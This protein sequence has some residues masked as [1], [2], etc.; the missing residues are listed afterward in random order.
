VGSL[1]PSTTATKPPSAREGVRS[2]YKSART[3]F[4]KHVLNKREE[5]ETDAQAFGT[6]AHLAILEPTEFEK[7]Y[8]VMPEF[9]DFRSSKNREARGRVARDSPG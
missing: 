9:G 6:A 4:R 5:D 8:I 2:A 7:R 3:F 1:R